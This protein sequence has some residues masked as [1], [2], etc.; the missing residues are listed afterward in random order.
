M[1]QLVLFYL[2]TFVSFHECL[3][4]FYKLHSVNSN[5]YWFPVLMVGLFKPNTRFSNWLCFLEKK[6]KTKPKTGFVSCL[7]FIHLSNLLCLSLKYS[8]SWEET[9]INSFLKLLKL[10]KQVYST[11]LLHFYAWIFT[12]QYYSFQDEW[13]IKHLNAQ[14]RT[15]AQFY[16]WV[17]IFLSNVNMSGL[18]PN[19]RK[20]TSFCIISLLEETIS[21]S[22]S[23]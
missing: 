7:Q 11:R 23:L 4:E 19:L 16:I 10:P 18:R 13:S 8:A 12:E 20:A 6:I 14:F 2:R 9:V 15:Y 1:V 3:L 21:F 17:P 5:F 22:E